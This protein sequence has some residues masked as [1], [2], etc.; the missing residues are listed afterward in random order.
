MTHLVLMWWFVA[1]GL[2]Y[3]AT[4]TLLGPF[5]SRSECNNIRQ[6]VSDTGWG[7]SSPC[8]EVPR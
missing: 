4:Y 3:S 8:W 5:S 7:K 2:G 6:W 1:V